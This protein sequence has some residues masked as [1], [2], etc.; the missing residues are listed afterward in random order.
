MAGKEKNNKLIEKNNL[1]IPEGEQV[2]KKRG[3]PKGSKNSTIRQDHKIQTNEGDNTKFLTHDL[4]LMRLPHIDLNSL[5][6]VK[7]RLDDYI[8]LCAEDDVKPSIASFALS[9]G[10]NRFDL[11]NYLNGR[12]NV[13]KNKECILAIKGIYDLINSYYEHIMNNG[14]INPVAGIFLMKNN[15]G[16]KDST[17]YTITTETHNDITD[18]D[19]INKAGLIE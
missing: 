2:V 18:D 1:I 7:Q 12:S 8:S 14:K 13:I 19:I 9:L 5:A 3:R 15:L 17:E 6:D 16:Y 11:F 4:K 10:I